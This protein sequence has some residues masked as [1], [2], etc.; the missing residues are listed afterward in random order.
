MPPR[1]EAV[2]L[3]HD[4]NSA[5][6]DALNI[7]RNNGAV[8]ALPE[9]QRGVSTKPEDSPAAYSIADTRNQTLTIQARF[10]C[11]EHGRKRFEVRA[12][13]PTVDP[14]LPKGCPRGCLPL[15]KI[16]AALIR[17]L[18]GNVLGDVK[19]KQVTCDHGQTAWE[20]FVLDN[21][22]LWSVGVGVHTTTWRWQYRAKPSDPW[23]DFDTS[24]HRVFVVLEL[25]K[26]PW[27]QLPFDTANTQ[28]PWIDVLDYACRWAAG[29]SDR[30]SAAAAVTS[31]VNGL[32][33]ALIEYDCPGGGGTHYG[34]GAFD[35]T[36]FLDRLSGGAGNGRYVNCTDCATFVS[37]FANILGCDLWQSQMG[38]DFGLN[39]IQA[40]GAG[41]WYPGCPG[42]LLPGFTYHEVAWKGACLEGDRLFDACLD[43]DGDADPTAAP[44]SALLPT[45]VIFGM[46]GS[47]H[48]RD[49][50][51][52]P[53]GRP[54]CAP[55]PSTRRRRS[56]A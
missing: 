48:Y 46:P 34:W 7:R 27:K 31:A 6:H 24:T 36:A 11:T 28:L 30:D 25:P 16:L 47:G 45:N 51:A 23:V 26:D 38:W 40:I 42:W 29:R 14:P 18:F 35:C 56:V 22:R 43:V 21:P 9:W 33:P 44:H 39:P 2:K 15:W 8:V 4:P 32:G 13:D 17:N 20:T 55:Q 52:T 5:T 50:L 19:A 53:G 3:N 49:R 54:A 12:V 1:L 41:A 10:T 37:T